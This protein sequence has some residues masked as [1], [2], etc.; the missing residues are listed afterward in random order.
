[1][2]SHGNRSRLL[3]GIC[4]IWWCTRVWHMIYHLRNWLIFC[5]R[6][7]IYWIKKNEDQFI[8]SGLISRTSTVCTLDLF[9]GLHRECF[10][11]RRLF[12]L[13]CLEI[14]TK[15][16]GCHNFIFLFPIVKNLR[17]LDEWFI[18]SKLYKIYTESS[19]YVAAYWEIHVKLSK[20]HSFFFQNIPVGLQLFSEKNLRT[21]PSA[22]Y[23]IFRF[24]A[25][26]ITR[27]DKK[28]I[29]WIEPALQASTSSR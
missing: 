4:M 3:L 17:G 18:A 10:S 26:L 28:V 22:H 11:T 29:E 21:L 20:L 12:S 13:G 6:K 19:K 16:T 24:L 7:R 1:M 27:N 9:V 2:P 5:M 8:P 23:D 14:P 15:W 25:R